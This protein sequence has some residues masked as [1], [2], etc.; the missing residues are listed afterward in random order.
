VIGL[1]LVGSLSQAQ[2]Q[3]TS[4]VTLAWDPPNGASDIAGYRVY[5]GTSN[6]IYPQTIN[7]G[8]RTTVTVP[9]LATGQTITSPPITT[10]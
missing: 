7:V 2:A 10:P 3:A 6:G 5:Y 4:S 8:N 1:L 9:N